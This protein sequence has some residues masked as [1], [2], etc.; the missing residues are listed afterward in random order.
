MLSRTAGPRWRQLT[1]EV[2]EDVRSGRRAPGSKLPSVAEQAAAGVSQ[3]TT[4]RAYRELVVMGLAVAVQGRGTY[5]A[6]PLPE[7]SRKL[8][9]EDQ[10]TQLRAVQGDL[11]AVARRL[12]ALEESHRALERR[13]AALETR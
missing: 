3:T 10:E 12:S 7:V 13:A 2:V 9:L 4:M 1:D 8:A 11:D 5:V 6:D